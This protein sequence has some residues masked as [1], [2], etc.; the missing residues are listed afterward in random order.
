M[1]R[2][3]PAFITTTKEIQDLRILGLDWTKISRKLKTTTKTLLK[4]R[5][6]NDYQVIAVIVVSSY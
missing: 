2:G 4:W 6:N 1:V 5:I 3:S